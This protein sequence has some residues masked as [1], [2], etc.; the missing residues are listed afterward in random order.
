[1]ARRRTRPKS[2]PGGVGPNLAH[3]VVQQL[4]LAAQCVALVGDD[5]R[6]PGEVSG[7]EGQSWVVDVVRLPASCSPNR[8]RSSSSTMYQVAC[9]AAGHAR[10][11]ARGAV[12]RRRWRRVRSSLRHWRRRRQCRSGGGEHRLGAYWGF[13]A[14]VAGQCAARSRG[15][16]A[17]R[18]IHQGGGSRTKLSSMLV[19]G[20]AGSRFSRVSGTSRLGSR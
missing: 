15:I 6:Q 18:H 5:R 1:L 11:D 13:G 17:I 9:R 19:S 20:T 12:A 2:L 3:P 16:A 4:R 14:Q 7:V 8:A 10:A